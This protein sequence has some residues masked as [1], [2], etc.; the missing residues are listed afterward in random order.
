M[1]F[2]EWVE[3]VA[4]TFARMEKDH[5]QA[6]VHA[7]RAE[8]GVTVNPGSDYRELDTALWNAIEDLDA[9]TVVNALNTFQILETENAR[10]IRAGAALS[11]VWPSFFTTFLEPEQHDFLDALVRLAEAEH[12]DFADVQWATATEVFASLGWSTSERADIGRAHA[13]V[14]ILDGA[15]LVRKRVAMGSIGAVHARPTYRGLVF[16][17][18]QVA[19]EW[20]QRL[21]EMAEEWETTTV[22]YK[23]EVKLDSPTQKGEFV[24]D[25]LGLATTKASGRERYLVIG[26]DNDTHAF[27]QPVTPDITQDRLEQILNQY[28]EP[29]P[30][31]RYFTVP[32]P[33]GGEAGV[34]E[35]RR[36]PARVP[37]RVRRDIGRIATGSV[38]VRHGSQTEPPTE[39][40]LEA[41][42]AE[43]ERARLAE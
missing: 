42:E 1:N 19:T 21:A 34:I 5:A 18:Q 10:K 6:G 33:G 29:R 8:L 30:E 22:E 43:G 12:D 7:V 32:M 15:G 2:I 4:V 9:L 24:K 36:D 38:I 39:L 14:N 27:A 31:V 37:Y 17:T 28:T 16:A 35:V 23:R 26:Y 3:K 13:I 40:E 20:Q 25:M 41:L 11:T